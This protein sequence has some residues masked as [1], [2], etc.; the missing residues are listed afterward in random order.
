MNFLQHRLQTVFEFAAIFR[1]SDQ[2]SQIESDQ[3]LRFQHIGNVTGNN[4]LRESFDDGGLADAGFADQHRIILRAS[5]QNLHHA[6]NFF[7]A[8][9]H[10]IELRFRASSVRSRAYFSS[11]A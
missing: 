9:N 8:A 10:R 3:A 11:A 4:A 6:A 1:A 2:R 5:R 7:I